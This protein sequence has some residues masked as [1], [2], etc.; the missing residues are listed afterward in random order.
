MTNRHS[1]IS[2]KTKETDIS[3]ELSLNGSGQNRIETGIGFLNHMLTLMTFH[4][5]FDLTLKAVGDTDVDAHHTIEDTGIVIG[6]AFK[7]ALGDKAGIRRYASGYLPMDETLCRTA[8]DISG[9]AY[10]VFR[11]DFQHALIGQFPT[12]MVVHFFRSLASEIGLTLH[13]EI[14]YGDNDHHKAEALFK[15]R[16]CM[17]GI[18]NYRSGNIRNLQNALQLIGFESKLFDTPDGLEDTDKIIIPGV[19]AFGHGMDNLHRYGFAGALPQLVK[20]KKMLGICVGMQLMFEEGYEHGTHKGL[21]FFAGC[22]RMMD[23]PLK[24]PHIGWN[25]LHQKRQDPLLE[26]I[27]DGE[28]VYYVHSYVCEP[29]D[30]DVIIADTEYGKRFC[31]IAGRDGIYGV[32]FHPEKSAESGIQLL[33]NFCRME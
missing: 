6:Q 2:R 28:W 33:K 31:G 26:K 12:D 3:A 18:V 16:K 23:V 17:I 29:T 24:I 9:R 20:Q 10:H 27:P 25:R 8:L 32:Q 7:T 11:C 21:G 15:G 14:L 13:Q 1:T 5:G 22:V 4:G 30:S 19:G